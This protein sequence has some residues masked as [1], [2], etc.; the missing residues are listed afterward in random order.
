M[1]LYQVY[2]L[3]RNTWVEVLTTQSK[4]EAQMKVN[5]L[6]SACIEAFWEQIQ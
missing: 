2:R 6:Q 1:A 4:R 3:E 5:D